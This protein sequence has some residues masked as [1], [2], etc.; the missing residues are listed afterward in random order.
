M[1]VLSNSCT[2]LYLL[3]H[4]VS[5]AKER[6]SLVFFWDASVCRFC[7]QSSAPVCPIIE[8]LVCYNKSTRLGR[9]TTEKDW[10]FGSAETF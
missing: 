6:M 3:F 2:D 5:F 4:N 8:P 9:N 7:A 1:V 10:S